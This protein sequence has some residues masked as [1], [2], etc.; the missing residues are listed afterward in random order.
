MH[1]DVGSLNRF[2]KNKTKQATLY[3]KQSKIYKVH[4]KK[5]AIP[6]LFFFIFVFSLQLTV[7]VQ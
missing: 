2:G 5:W 7:N 6:C 3:F 1:N 4:H